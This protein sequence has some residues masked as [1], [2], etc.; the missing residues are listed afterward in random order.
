M[1]ILVAG[2]LINKR[3]YCRVI[4]FCCAVSTKTFLYILCWC[5]GDMTGKAGGF[6]PGRVKGMIEFLH[7]IK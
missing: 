3:K 6:M 2:R 1:H 7:N 5:R 4:G